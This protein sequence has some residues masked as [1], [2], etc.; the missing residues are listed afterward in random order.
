MIEIVQFDLFELHDPEKD[1]RPI[2][3][4]CGSGKNLQDILQF[5]LEKIIKNNSIDF[6]LICKILSEKLQ[7]K[8]ESIK[9]ILN[10][11]WVP[12]VILESLC[13][14]AAF[15][16]KEFTKLKEDVQKEIQMLRVSS[17]MSR[18]IKAVKSLDLT[19]CKIAGAHAADGCLCGTK[20]SLFVLK[21]QFKQT[22]KVFSDWLNKEFD[23]KIKIKKSKNENSFGMSFC[24][25]P[26]SR[27][28]TKF[29]GFKNGKKVDVVSEP[30][31]IK[32]AGLEFEK[33]FALGV[34]TFEASINSDRTITM[35][36]ISK[37]LRDDIATILEKSNLKII[38]SPKPDSKGRWSIRTLELTH[39]EFSQFLAFFEVNSSAWVKIKEFAEGFKITPNS[40]EEVLDTFNN[41]FPF[42]VKT[43]ET[44]KKLKVTTT[45]EIM[46]E[47]ELGKTTVRRH[48][49]LLKGMNIT[50]VTR[51]PS[52]FDINLIPFG[53]R[54]G[55]NE[56]FRVFLFKEIE[57]KLGSF[58]NLCRLIDVKDFTVTRWK[59][60]ERRIEIKTLLKLIGIAEILPEKLEKNIKSF[61]KER[62]FFN[63]NI[64][65]WKIPQV[66]I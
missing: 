61:N 51:F 35:S 18:P 38:K 6:K 58:A 53:T 24:N 11:K 45:K 10:R 36:V 4:I 41:R 23:L 19:L 62:I 13:K 43:F 12:L 49:N 33:A 25:K 65:S 63:P 64:N 28:L 42:L 14:I 44:I 55:L 29:L 7:C 30:E 21:D 17:S 5:L 26:F 56:E 34:L 31:I 15:S 59:N 16:E 47:M 46:N 37:N 32:L 54:I 8:K 3:W 40:I 60:G 39:L 2:S 52:C 48:I 1:R 57:A 27:F 9:A 66:I 20:E 22:I 50:Q